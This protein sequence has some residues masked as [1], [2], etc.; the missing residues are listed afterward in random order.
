VGR[1]RV[2]GQGRGTVVTGT[3]TGGTVAVDDEL[4]VG[5]RAK[6]CGCRSI[7][8]AKRHVDDVGRATGWR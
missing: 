8:T 6:P 3:L 2:R 5:A 1:P 4:E 7:E